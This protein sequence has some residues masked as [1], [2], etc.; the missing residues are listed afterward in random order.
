MS[1]IHEALEDRKS[2]SLRKANRPSPFLRY[3]IETLIELGSKVQ[4]TS[5]VLL[6]VKSE[7]IA[8]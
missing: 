8:G 4:E 2:S 6:K 5:E 7:A 1:Q 3:D